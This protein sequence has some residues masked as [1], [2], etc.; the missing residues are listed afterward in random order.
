MREFDGEIGPV[1]ALLQE[2]ACLKMWLAR[3]G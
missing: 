2:C 3:C 1:E